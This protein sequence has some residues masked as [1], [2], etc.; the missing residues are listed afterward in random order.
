MLLFN[1]G[2]SGDLKIHAALVLRMQGIDTEA[3]MPA[4]TGLGPGFMP[5]T[6]AMM[7]R[8]GVG[9]RQLVR[10]ADEV[11]RREYGLSALSQLLLIWSAYRQLRGTYVDPVRC[12]GGG[13]AALA[14]SYMLVYGPQPDVATLAE[15]FGC[16]VRQLVY[17]ARRIASC[18]DRIAREI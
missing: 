3:I 12:V 18:L 11:L 13:A 16:D 8:L 1:E 6:K 4:R 7:D 14:Y 9:E 17:Y 10:Y 5:D 15:Q 2:V